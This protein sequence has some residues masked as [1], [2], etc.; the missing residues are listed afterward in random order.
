MSSE[1]AAK[2]HEQ[3]NGTFL[4]Q[5]KTVWPSGL[6]RWLKAPVRKGV[7]SNPTAVISYIITSTCACIALAGRRV[8]GKLWQHHQFPCLY[9][10]IL[11]KK[12]FLRTMPFPSNS[13]QADCFISISIG[14]QRGCSSNGRALAQH[15]RG[16]GIDAQLLHICTAETRPDST[17]FMFARA[18][19]HEERNPHAGHEVPIQPRLE[20]GSACSGEYA[21]DSAVP[22]VLIA[23]SVSQ[24]G[25]TCFHRRCLEL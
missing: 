9:P 3:I 14:F 12:R 11:L 4:S 2:C 23:R 17:A 22:Q 21:R 5:C 18:H 20:A 7:G 24:R 1:D 16:T 10:P 19:G 25:I 6:R 8:V 13:K 15:A